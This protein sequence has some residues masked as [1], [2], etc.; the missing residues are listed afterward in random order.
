MDLAAQLLAQLPPEA[1]RRLATRADL[2]ELLQA[3]LDD[4]RARYPELA[5]EP[6]ALLGVIAPILA[7]D[8]SQLDALHGGDLL[9]A[10]ACAR[11]EVRALGA[12]E[13]VFG[14][15]LDRAIDR[16][17]RLGVAAAEFRQLVRERL[18]VAPG[19]RAPRIAGYRGKGTL[20]SWVRVTASRLVIDL[21]RRHDG[22]TRPDDDLARRLATAE[23]DPELDFFRSAYA[24]VLPAAFE[25]AL[26]SLT[27]RQRN[28]LRQRYLQELSGE[29]L[30][31]MYGVHRSTLFEWLAG[32]RDAL[33]REL[34]S[35]LARRLPGDDLDSVVAML[36][37]KL[38][39]SVRRMLDS[40]LEEET[41]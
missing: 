11:G 33:L 3:Q 14:A 16:S 1:R 6:A 23:E 26:A 8:P 38:E 19:H 41:P 17:P 40:R 2:A 29:Q 34:Q 32:A 4:A 20:K 9:L 7:D 36:G 5:G 31:V 18:F 35:A 24:D 25:E 27:V 13:R 12:F 28:L 37:S 39:L 22:S 15:D 10:E 21:A 30:A